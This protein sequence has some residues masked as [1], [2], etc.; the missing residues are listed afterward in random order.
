MTSRDRQDGWDIS[1]NVTG[2]GMDIS[3]HVTGKGMGISWNVTGKG[4]DISWHVTR[5]VGALGLKKDTVGLAGAVGFGER[6]FFF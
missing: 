1:W 6:I 3:W 2:K 4:W 5:N